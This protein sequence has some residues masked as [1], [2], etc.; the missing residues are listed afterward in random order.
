MSG[1]VKCTS[2]TASWSTPSSTGTAERAPWPRCSARAGE[3]PVTIPNRDV[4]RTIHRPFPG[5]AA[6]PLA[7]HRGGGKSAVR[8]ACRRGADRGHHEEVRIDRCDERQT[9]EVTYA[10]ICL[11][12]GVV[13]E[14]LDGRPSDARLEGSRQA[15]PELCNSSE[16]ADFSLL[17]A[18]LGSDGKS[19]YF[20]EHTLVSPPT[21]FT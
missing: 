20:G 1:M 15:A 13:L 14:V 7:L 11:R 2:R 21:T 6:R 18:R 19:S 10:L 12:T 3:T 8:Q 5:G 4:T 17:F 16:T 9:S